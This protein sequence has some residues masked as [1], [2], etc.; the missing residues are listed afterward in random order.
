MR[1]NLL[2]KLSAFALGIVFSCCAFAANPV[3][4]ITT[5]KG[6]ITLELYQDKAPLTVENFLKYANAGFYQGTIFHRVI[7][8][9]MIQGGGFTKDYQQKE[10][11][12][13]I[14]NEAANGLLND[15]GTIAMARTNSPHSA[16]AQFFINVAKN[17]FLNYSAATARGFGYCVFGRVIDG[18]EVVNQIAALPTGPAG[19]FPSDVPQTSVVIEKLTV[20][21]EKAEN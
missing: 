8:N 2:S 1:Q 7:Q 15:V 4:E 18:M 9:F 13:P 10:T 14:E 20:K 6:K 12:A 21:K 5:N 3:V 16:T 17:D 19:P 11:N